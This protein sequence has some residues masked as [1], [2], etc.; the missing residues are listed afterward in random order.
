MLR[1]NLAAGNRTE[2]L[3]RQARAYTGLSQSF[4]IPETAC[5]SEHRGGMNHGQ[6][7]GGILNSIAHQHDT[8][9]TVQRKLPF[10][11]AARVFS[12][13]RRAKASWSRVR[14]IRSARLPLCC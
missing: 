6:G 12:A 7:V 9:I 1:L 4:R 2:R 13:N 11:S 3:S 8:L 10:F 14:A 5:C